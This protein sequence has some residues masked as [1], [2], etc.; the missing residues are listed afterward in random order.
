M[1]IGLATRVRRSPHAAPVAVVL[2]LFALSR[3]AAWQR[4]VR[5]DDSSLGF[6]WQYIDPELLKHH[7]LQSLWYLHSQPPGYNLLLGLD[8]KVFGSHF[9]TAAHTFQIALG[10]AIAL[11]L[12][13]LLFSFGVSR[14]WAAGLATV[15]VV[16][17]S[18]IL[19]ENWMFYDYFVAALL[20]IAAAAFAHF[21]R[22]PSAWRSFL[23]F[24]ALATV[25]FI[26]STFQIVPLLL[27]LAFML[28]AFTSARRAI[29]VGALVP[30]LLVAGLSVKNWV[31]FGTP[32]TSSWAGMNLMQVDQHASHPDQLESLIDRGVVSPIV[33]VRV[34]RPL[35]Y[36]K[37]FAAPSN[38]FPGVPVLHE[39]TKPSGDVNFNNIEYVAI[40]N[41][42]MHAF[43][44]VL[45]RRP[46]I[47]LRG[48]W[49]GLQIATWP[50]DTDNYVLP[51]R[52]KIAPWVRVYD[53]VVLGQP[54]ARWVYGQPT[55]TAWFLIIGYLI[56]LIFGAVETIRLLL[57][58][59]GSATAAFI[60]LLLTYATL[61]M[62]LGE[63]VENQRVRLPTDSLVFLLLALG[64]SRLIARRRSRPAPQPG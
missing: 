1:S 35:S 24:G 41:E 17:P 28:V 36:Y 25:C 14:W 49:S 37:G 57:R 63:V 39:K 61:V 22:R 27:V 12:Y 5:F 6:F 7:L 8:L 21:E 16:S 51:N 55:G 58:R 64:A 54:R 3:L 52:K 19:Y 26:R 33:S 60:W 32:S 45:L 30:L 42:Y 10:V 29:L 38:A 62:T 4:G 2:V 56:A 34:F 18:M 13:A 53:T 11:S 40:S 50:S 43:L 47:Y 9:G 20:L 44:Q 46:G 48:I 23:V 31:L 59:S 15:F